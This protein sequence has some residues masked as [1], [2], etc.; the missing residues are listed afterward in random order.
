L[1]L[2]SVAQY[3]A[4]VEAAEKSPREHALEMANSIGSAEIAPGTSLRLHLF[5]KWFSLWWI[6]EPA[7]R[8]YLTAV[9]ESV[10][11]VRLVF[12]TEQPDKVYALGKARKHIFSSEGNPLDPDVVVAVAR[13]RG[14]DVV[15]VKPATR[16][17]PF[18]AKVVLP[19]FIR[20]ILWAGSRARRVVY[21]LSGWFKPVGQDR[22]PRGTIAVV[23]DHL[24]W[25]T[26]AE[27]REAAAGKNDAV[28]GGVLNELNADASN[29]VLY[30]DFLSLTGLG[31]RA[32]AEKAGRFARIDYRPLE[33]YVRKQVLKDVWMH[34]HLFR[35][36]WNEVKGL[37]ALS[38]AASVDG[39]ELWE[40]IRTKMEFFF[41]FWLPMGA[42]YADAM[43]SFIRHE[44]P[45]VIVVVGEQRVYGRCFLAAAQALGVPTLGMQHG[46]IPRDHRQY[47]HCP[48]AVPQ[49]GRF[50]GTTACPIPDKT[51]VYGELFKRTLVEEG[52]YP[53]DSVAVTGQPAYDFLYNTTDNDS[54]ERICQQLGIDPDK[55]IVVLATHMHGGAGDYQ[56]R[57]LLETVFDA[58]IEFP[59]L[60]LVVKLHPAEDPALHRRVAGERRLL[61]DIVIVKDVNLFDLLRASGVLITAHSTVALEAMLFGKPVVTVNVTGTPDVMPYAERGAAVSVR[62]AAHLVEAIRAVLTEE[63]LRRRLAES[64][65]AFLADCLH[66]VDGKAARR[67]VDLALG[68]VEDLPARDS[69]EPQT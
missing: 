19:S 25:R 30:A 51:A 33:A 2:R 8:E 64:R 31:L 32:I 59:E 28:V 60:K 24:N 17:R 35:S 38:E 67:V 49:N 57:R 61:D 42:Y 68:M 23:S 15:R 62:D 66:P 56:K 47:K 29:R 58:M 21:R 39:V 12:E 36:K 44:Q 3:V 22:S 1:D 18:S 55:E 69:E 11:Q 13:Q 45:D 5:Y 9:I 52:G 20:F 46:V 54:K 6:M 63:D 34:A 7:L 10:R 43:A 48:D 41:L 50:V 27:P 53:A 16:S 37:P 65:E 14:I 40:A 26:V 4:Q